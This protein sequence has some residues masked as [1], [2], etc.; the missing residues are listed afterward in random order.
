MNEEKELWTVEVN[1]NDDAISPYAWHVDTISRTI[2]KNLNAAY[3]GQKRQ[4]WL[5]V[6][7]EISF[8]DACDLADKY[9]E[10]IKRFRQYCSKD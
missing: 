3:Q 8:D 7:L 9:R 2:E 5:L 4:P 6:G 10:H 1:L